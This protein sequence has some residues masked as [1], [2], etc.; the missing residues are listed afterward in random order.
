MKTHEIRLFTLIGVLHFTALV[1]AIFSGNIQMADS[2]EYL[3]Q[4]E[5]LFQYGSRCSVPLIEGNCD[6]LYLTKRPP[7]YPLFAGLFMWLGAPVFILLIF[8][9]L[10][11]LFN[12]YVMVRLMREWKVGG[13]AIALGLSLINITQFIYAN[14]LMSELLLQT[15]FLLLV[16]CISKYFSSGKSGFVGLAA[17]TLVL[18]MLTKP[19]AYPLSVLFA[20]F[21]LWRAV[22][23]RTAI[24]GLW[25]VIPL[26]T[27][28]AYSGWNEQQTGY[29]HFSSIQNINLVDYNTNFF[30]RST[31][32]VEVADSVLR[33]IYTGVEDF[34]TFEEKQVFLRKQSTDILSN[35][36]IA[37]GWWHFRGAMRGFFDPGRFD[38][39][40]FA[41]IEGETEEGLLYKLNEEGIGAALNHLLKGPGFLTFLLFVTFLFNTVIFFSWL[42]ILLVKR[43]PAYQLALIL[44]LPIY[45]AFATGPLNASRFMLPVLPFLLI[46]SSI[47]LNCLFTCEWKAEKKATGSR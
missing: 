26:V 2:V 39:Y 34:E 33:E 5:N 45:V 3:V 13:I 1:F 41:G 11:S 42:G 17:L 8:Q 25:A 37:Y 29:R 19:V 36:L 10:L 46:G 15:W 21:F 28:I 32:G 24:G 4:A 23:E 40:N 14:V 6:P 18:A 31:Y 7:V 12:I 38:L 20:G 44:F 35:H 9:N 27:V 30:L 22:R 43:L 16:F 47:F